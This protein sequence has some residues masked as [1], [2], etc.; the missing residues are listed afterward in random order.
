MSRAERY[1]YIWCDGRGVVRYVGRG[2]LDR[3]TEHGKDDVNP[4][5]A[6][7]FKAF[8]P[9]FPEVLRC[10]DE[11]T[12]EFVEGA[13]ISAATRYRFDLTNR[14]LDKYQ[15]ASL[16]VPAELAPRAGLPSLTPVEVADLVGGQALF[17]YI[18]QNSLADPERGRI[19]PLAPAPIAVGDRIRHWWQMASWLQSC[20][21]DPTV[22]RPVCL[23]GL[24][25]KPR[26]RYV[27]GAIDLREI[28]W[29]AVEVNG[30]QIGFPAPGNGVVT[31]DVLDAFSLRGRVVTGVSFGNFRHEFFRLY[32]Q[33]GQS[34]ATSLDS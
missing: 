27:A 14:R 21:D 4:D 8:E 16:G 1:V 31:D 11:R 17:V 26:Y 15:F 13:L 25:G 34:I 23:I 29:Q 12:A 22:P 18:S 30:A 10:P 24:S 9:L 32:D 20:R 33:S 7:A 3:I 6:A 2:T 28:E 19:D 5:L